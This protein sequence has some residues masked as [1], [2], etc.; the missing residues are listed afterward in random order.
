MAEI[1]Q[2][3]PAASVSG[4]RAQ[5]CCRVSVVLLASHISLPGSAV[6]QLHD[7]MGEEAAL[8]HP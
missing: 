2:M 7:D 5:R 4:K 3:L 8:S 6:N 1:M